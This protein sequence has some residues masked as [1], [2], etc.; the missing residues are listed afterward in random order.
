M[1]LED[2]QSEV[3]EE[4]G[5]VRKLWDTVKSPEYQADVLGGWLYYTP[6]YGLQEIAFGKETN[7]MMMTRLIGLGMHAA[8]MRPVGKLRD[9][10]A[11]KRGVTKKSPFKDKLKINLLAITP[12]QTVAYALMLTGGMALSNKWNLES[13]FY[14]WMLGTALS[15]VHAFPACWVQ[16][17]IRGLY[18]LA[19]AIR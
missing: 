12:I 18:G 14:N 3:Y 16:D 10:L 2:I 5:I 8:L 17:K 7:E 19:P 4:R 11:Q 15:A 6:I 13:S 1:T 9:Y